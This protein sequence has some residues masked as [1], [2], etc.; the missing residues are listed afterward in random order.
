MGLTGNSEV[1]K[2]A[3]Q[4]QYNYI[5]P[6]DGKTIGIHF[7]K[8]VLQRID[9]YS[10]VEAIEDRFLPDE[11]PMV[12]MILESLMKGQR[13]QVQKIQAVQQHINSQ[14]KSSEQHLSIQD[15]E[16]INS[17]FEMLEKKHTKQFIE[18]IYLKNDKKFEITL[19]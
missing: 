7:L 3:I 17:I 13:I 11:K 4:K 10:S 18:S 6:Q 1:N 2:D 16:N 19:D 9:L 8:R 15:K 12:L 14:T 5:C